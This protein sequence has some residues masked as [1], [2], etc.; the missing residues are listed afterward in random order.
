MKTQK[1]QPKKTKKTKKADYE[2]FTILVTTERMKIASRLARLAGVSKEAML[3]GIVATLIDIGTDE[4][5]NE[6]HRINDAH[7]TIDEIPRLA[8]PLPKWTPEMLAAPHVSKDERSKISKLAEYAGTTVEA[9]ASGMLSLLL[10]GP[11]DNELR[12]GC[13]AAA[14]KKAA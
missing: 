14:R 2:V 12:A 7:E 1:T 4:E 8:E 10:E 13:I 6:F 11:L 3:S 9:M 5:E